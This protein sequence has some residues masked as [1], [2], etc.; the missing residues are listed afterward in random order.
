MATKPK[1]CFFQIN[2]IMTILLLQIKSV[3]DNHKNNTAEITNQSS[4]ERNAQGKEIKVL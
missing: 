2:Y 3:I 1:M 4:T